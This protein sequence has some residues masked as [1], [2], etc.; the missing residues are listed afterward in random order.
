MRLGVCCDCKIVWIIL[1]IK[2]LR[3]F[4]L[5]SVYAVIFG[6]WSFVIALVPD[7]SLWKCYLIVYTT[8]NSS[9][10]NITF[11]SLPVCNSPFPHAPHSAAL[12]LGI[13]WATWHVLLSLLIP[14]LVL[15]MKC[16]LMSQPNL[17]PCAPAQPCLCS[18]LPFWVLLCYPCSWAAP[19]LVRSL[20][21]CSSVTPGSK[22]ISLTGLWQ[23]QWLQLKILIPPVF[24][25]RTFCQIFLWQSVFISDL[26]LRGESWWHRKSCYM[27]FFHK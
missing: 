25:L 24:S 8:K 17:C 2:P 21:C 14:F 22:H 1:L 26:T 27:S 6:V 16:R 9:S 3:N 13:T 19:M 7:F 10:S 18:P 12:V 23:A 11:Q 15:T 20:P 5:C 4:N